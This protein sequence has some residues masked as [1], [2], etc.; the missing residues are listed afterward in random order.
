VLTNTPLLSVA[1]LSRTHCIAVGDTNG[2]PDRGVMLTTSDGG[3][4]WLEEVRTDTI[5][6]LKQIQFTDSLHGWILYWFDAGAGLLTTRDGGNS[7]EKRQVPAVFGYLSFLDSL[8]GFA[9][10]GGYANLYKTTDGGRS[11]VYRTFIDP[12]NQPIPKSLSFADTL[13]G[14]LF[15][16]TSQLGDLS[17]TIYRT[18]DGGLSWQQESV[19]LTA[20]I[21][22]A[23]ML[24][25]LHGWAA[26]SGGVVLGYH[27]TATSV[28]DR[29]P[30][31]LATSF[32]LY[33]NYPNPFNSSTSIEY[34]LA[35]E[36][37]VTLTVSD[38]LGRTITVLVNKRQQAGFYRTS[39]E[40]TT[41]GSGVYF[42]TLT[43]RGGRRE[44]K[45]LML[46]K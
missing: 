44:A 8:S 7:W 36:G 27:P 4:S 40:A 42:Y 45:R 32:Q 2:Y 13:N 43:I 31:A 11:W 28:K 26:C 19:G 16:L 29:A 3:V 37:E 38:L 30:N 1:A 12:A 20:R 21:F 18:H 25:T 34:Q 10:T 6:T 5:S 24:D 9:V 35:H 17:E 39:W 22:S 41:V 33:Q 15:S 23:Q 46:L 14:W